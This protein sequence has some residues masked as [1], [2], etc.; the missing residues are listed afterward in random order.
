MKTN[1]QTILE[2]V[3]IIH[4]VSKDSLFVEKCF[5]EVESELKFVSDFFHIN[6]IQS[7]LLATIISKTCD[8]AERLSRIAD[9]FGIEEI[10]MMRYLPDIEELADRKIIQ[11]EKHRY[12]KLEY[13]F[14]YG[15]YFFLSK[16]EPIPLELI[17]KENKEYTFSQCLGDIEGLSNLKDQKEI[18]D[19]YLFTY[20]F[21]QI[22]TQY[23]NLKLIQY[24]FEEMKGAT[25]DAFVFLD[26]IIDA[27]K[28]YDNNYNTELRSTVD[29]CTFT[30]REA[31]NYISAFLDGKTILNKLNLVEKD[32]KEFGNRHNL[33]LTDKAVKM[34]RE[35]EG[36][37]FEINE[38]SD[39]LLY[40][41]KIQTVN[42]FH[43]RNEKAQLD[44]IMN[45]MSNNAFG[46]LQRRLRINNLPTGITVLFYG[47]PGTGKTETVYQ[48]A[49]KYKRSVFKVEISETKS[50]W[51][52]E[53]QKLVKKIFTDYNEFKKSEKICPILLFNEADAIIGKRKI[54]GSSNV[55][56][57]EN[58]IQNI[59][60]EELENFDGILFATSNLIR[61]IDA[62]FE[63]RFLFK[64]K[65]D[66]PDE[67]NAVKI[68]RNK[69]P[70]LS[71]REARKLV[72]NFHFSGGEMENIARKCIM[73]EV[74]SDKKI[75]FECIM[76][77]CENEKWDESKKTIGF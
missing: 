46:Q 63:R 16:N 66:I 4:A 45:S 29:D 53:S 7:I 10:R 48:I 8:G 75:T 13:G 59:L 64:I 15:L 30:R 39:K 76:A 67:E 74:I 56:D 11:R 12:S 35:W 43:N 41:D 77:F 25:I 58:A 26:T 6:K 17:T 19:E 70:S 28:N 23:K 9:H 57:T 18:H 49:K 50:M 34:L 62:A 42:L 55:A 65:F 44:I 32:K 40:P 2:A 73:E 61:N 36:I 20:Q 47:E 37:K 71:D 38:K 51:F 27:V 5:S 54:A 33:R 69:F 72:Q 24:L 22:L 3:E 68:W 60:L 52:G 21:W 1:Q 14:S 31:F